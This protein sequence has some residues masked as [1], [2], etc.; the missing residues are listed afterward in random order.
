MYEGRH[1]LVDQVRLRLGLG[2]GL[3]LEAGLPKINLGH[4]PENLWT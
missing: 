1:I 4:R 3:G 2:L